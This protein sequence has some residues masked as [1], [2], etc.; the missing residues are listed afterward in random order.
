MHDIACTVAGDPPAVPF[1][2][3]TASYDLLLSPDGSTTRTYQQQLDWK[4][5]G[6][7]TYLEWLKG[8]FV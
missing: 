4:R 7:T 8:G 3:P 6:G 5:P 2:D 1:G